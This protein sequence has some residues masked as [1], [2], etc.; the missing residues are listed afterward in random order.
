MKLA[1]DGS[2]IRR[3]G[4]FEGIYL[5]VEENEIVFYEGEGRQN[6]NYFLYV[7]DLLADDWE[8]IQ[9]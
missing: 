3:M 6:S 5:A 4:W 8:V 2:K 9:E 7:W 1:L